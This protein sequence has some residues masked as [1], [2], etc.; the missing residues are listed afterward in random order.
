M[1]VKAK[2][3]F[4]DSLKSARA[5][6]D[7]QYQIL[8]ELISQ[9][10]Q[11]FQDSPSAGE[12][13]ND[14]VFDSTA[15]FA[16]Q[17]AASALL[18][19]LYPGTAK[20]T[21]E[22]TPPNSLRT[23]SKTAEFYERMTEKVAQAMD[24][25]NANL[26]IALD[27]YMLDQQIFGTSG[28]GVFRGNKSKLLFKPYG[29][30][31]MYICEGEGGQVDAIYLL[32]EWT[33]KR[34]VEEYGEENVSEKVLAKYQAGDLLSK[35]K[36][37]IIIEPRKEVKAEAGVLAMPIA[38]YHV[39][40]DCCHLLKESGFSSMPIMVGRFR[41][42]N[43]EMYGRSNG[44]AALPDVAEIQA[45]REA[46]IIGTEKALDM[47]KGVMSDG[48]FGGGTIDTSA[49]AVTVFDSA[50]SMGNTPIFDIGSPP[51]IN[52]ALA[53]LADLKESIAQHFNLDRLIDFN[54]DVQMT[55]GEAQIRNQIR[56][57]SLSSLYA[58]QITEVFTPLIERVVTMLFE[59]GDLGVV[60]GSEQEAELLMRG[61]EPYYFPDEIIELI[62]SGQDIYE[63]TYK[64][65]AANAQ[66]SEEYIAT[67]DVVG[68]A[69]QMMQ[70]DPS[71]RHR[72]DFHEAVK[73]L[74]EVR[75]LPNQVI[76]EDDEVAALVQ[77]DQ[78]K[79]Q[80]ATALDAM[81]QGADIVQK[82]AS[83]NQQTGL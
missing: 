38:S 63:V 35:A 20:Q 32:N 57:A 11:N 25:P 40:Y 58:R 44:M 56:N 8:G 47:P 23:T 28:V 83:A 43:Y 10:K 68:F 80:G 7:S 69:T 27:E 18:G 71:V 55:F 21:L 15:T 49:R 76:R 64:T 17:A 22:L 62:E 5:N 54:N 3:K 60:K 2:K 74:S 42:L 36:I 12:F 79:E 59:D 34:I 52:V 82:L 66:R 72:V 30:K 70:V 45:L 67:V 1:D 46:V 37:L 81:G 48:V 4:F 24:D 26:L 14:E 50:N 78:A 77:Q 9:T 19:M 53:R 16:A 73:L 61:E 39:E 31:E 51:D 65:Q 6:W 41:K 29:V 33:I 75:G 13:L